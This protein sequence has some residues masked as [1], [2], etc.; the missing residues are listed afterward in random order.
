MVR[1]MARQT[2]KLLYGGAL[3]LA[4]VGGAYALLGGSSR[5]GAEADPSPG[6]ASASGAS[7]GERA[8]APTEAAPSRSG[9]SDAEAEDAAEVERALAAGREL[10]RRRRGPRSTTRAWPSSPP[11]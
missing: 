4:L 10:S 9:L 3:A 5:E 7:S 8:G 11:R 6:A 1:A 2:D